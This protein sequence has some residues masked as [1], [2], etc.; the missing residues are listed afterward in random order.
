MK[1]R[2]TKILSLALCAAVLFAAVGTSGFALTGEG[3]ESEDENQTTTINVSAEAETSK[4]ETVYVLAGADGTVQKIIVS[5]WSN[6]LM[7][8][9]CFRENPKL[10]KDRSPNDGCSETTAG[11]IISSPLS[12][13]CIMLVCAKAENGTATIRHKID[14]SILFLICLLFICKF[15]QKN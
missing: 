7:G 13:G 9:F 1:N 12:D 11:S 8:A 2:A 10:L 4:D 6:F 14:M 3:K 5:D 15:R